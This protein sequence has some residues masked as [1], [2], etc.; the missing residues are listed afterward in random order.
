MLLNPNL[1]IL[2]VEDD[3]SILELILQWL[4]SA[5]FEPEGVRNGMLAMERFKEDKFDLAIVDLDLPFIDGLTL[6]RN[7]KDIRPQMPVIICTAYADSL[8]RETISAS[9]ADS[10]VTKPIVLENLLRQIQRLTFGGNDE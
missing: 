8:S 1:K 5:G 4:K 2:V 9:G 3:D 6:S 7:F 10:V